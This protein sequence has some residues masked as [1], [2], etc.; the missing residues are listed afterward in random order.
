MKDNGHVYE[1]LGISKHF[2]VKPLLFILKI[3]TF[4]LTTTCCP[5]IY[6]HCYAHV[7]YS[8]SLSVSAL[9]SHTLLHFLVAA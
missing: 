2:T 5:M 4:T 6:T 3:L 1:A 8:S 9:A 7:L